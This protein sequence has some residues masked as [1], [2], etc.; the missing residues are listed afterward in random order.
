MHASFDNALYFQI[1]RELEH[2]L[3]GGADVWERV[4]SGTGTQMHAGL[5]AGMEA[6]M[7]ACRIVKTFRF[8]YR[9]HTSITLANLSRQQS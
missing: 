5:Y 7:D 3:C 9:T 4:H 8:C 6:E 1:L 2:E